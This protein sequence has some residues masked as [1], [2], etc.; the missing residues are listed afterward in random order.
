M[1]LMLAIPIMR[2]ITCLKQILE[3][4]FKRNSSNNKNFEID[5]EVTNADTK[6]SM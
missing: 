5:L 6:E 1:I 4:K 2:L 3:K